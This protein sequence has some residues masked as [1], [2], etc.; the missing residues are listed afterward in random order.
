MSRESTRRPDF[1]RPNRS[2][3]S[4]SSSS[5]G[6]GSS[7]HGRGNAE[8]P[9]QPQGDPRRARRAPSRAQVP[10]HGPRRPPTAHSPRGPL[11]RDPLMGRRCVPLRSRVAP[12]RR[13]GRAG[14]RAA[15]VGE[16]CVASSWRSSRSSRS[17]QCWPISGSSTA[18]RMLMR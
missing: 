13:F 10:P 11:T 9:R 14:P 15:S 5:S 8:P 1:T 17:P 4:S 3:S 6:R 12:M 7:A 2:S 16:G 18:S